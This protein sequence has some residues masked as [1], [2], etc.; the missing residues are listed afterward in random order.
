MR[1][2]DAF[3]RTFSRVIKSALVVDLIEP[4]TAI[5]YLATNMCVGNKREKGE[6]TSV[7]NI[8]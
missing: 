3:P 5:N 8:H 4:K 7:I 2:G 1:L 6:L